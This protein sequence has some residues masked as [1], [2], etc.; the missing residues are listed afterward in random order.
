MDNRT[1]RYFKGDAGYPFGYGLSYTTFHY[2]ALK[3]PA[4]I[5]SRTAIP[6]SV[7]VTNTGRLSGDEVVQLYI[8]YKGQTTK[9]PQRA[10]KGFQRITLKAGETRTIK[11]TLDAA[12][13]A[14]PAADGSAVYPKGILSISVGGGQP[15]LSVRTTSNTVQ[16][17]MVIN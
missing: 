17:G 11:F 13:L 15:G 14:I 6:V 10:L 5:K 1:Y 9:V 4:S 16:G 2:D 8:S 12:S 7:T 3:V